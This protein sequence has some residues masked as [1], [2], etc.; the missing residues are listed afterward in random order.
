MSYRVD[1]KQ[2]DAPPSVS[3]AEFYGTE[4]TAWLKDVYWLLVTDDCLNQAHTD[5][6]R[7]THGIRSFPVPLAMVVQNLDIRQSYT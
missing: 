7:E 2:F 4:S 1:A 6:V 3:A 5:T